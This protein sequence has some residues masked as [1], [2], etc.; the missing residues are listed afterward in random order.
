MI[1]AAD[2]HAEVFDRLEHAKA[3]EVEILATKALLP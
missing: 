1:R 2:H 3:E